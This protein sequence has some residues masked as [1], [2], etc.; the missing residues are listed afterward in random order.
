MVAD[1][2]FEGELVGTVVEEPAGDTLGLKTGAFTL[3]CFSGVAR[4]GSLTISCDSLVLFF[5]KEGTKEGAF[6]FKIA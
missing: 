2:V 1:V 5:K 6:G 3:N 4:F